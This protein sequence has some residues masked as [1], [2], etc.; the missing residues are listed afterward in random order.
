V[1]DAPTILELLDKSALFRGIPQKVL[2]PL[3]KESVVISLTQGEKLLSPGVRNEHV[4]IIIAGQLSVHLTLSN[5]DEPLAILNPG[6]CVGEMS[7][8]LDSNVSAYVIANTNCQLLAIGYSTFWSLIKGSND[9]SRNMLNILV[10]RIRMGNEA[11]ADN[12]TQHDKFPDKKANIDKLT[13]LYSPHG[14][15]DKFVHLLHLCTVGNRPLSLIMLHI[16]EAETNTAFASVK[17][18]GNEQP[19]RT[20]AQTILTQLRPDDCAARLNGNIFIILLA[21]LSISDVRVAAERLRETVSR[22][23]VFMPD[24]NPLPPVTISAGICRVNEDDNWSRLTARGNQA[25]ERASMGGG[26][27]I[28][29]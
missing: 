25:L 14:I 29:D 1:I 16:D 15:Q 26:N 9:S 11:I 17:E 10:Q 3:F 8:L 24:G 20:I 19:L 4:Y 12:L 5:T 2:A 22:T 7:V 23:P 13:G 6:E 27:R 18:L 21:N 28:S